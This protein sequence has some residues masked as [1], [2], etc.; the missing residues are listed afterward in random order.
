MDDL[1][2][3]KFPPD[4]ATPPSWSWMAYAGGKDNSGGIDYFNPDFDKFDWQ[5]IDSP[6]SQSDTGKGTT[7]LRTLSQEYDAN[8][9]EGKNEDHAVEIILDDNSK[10]IQYPHRCVVL[11]IQ[12]GGMLV[13]DKRHYILVI[14]ATTKPGVYERIGAGFVPGICINGQAR[15]VHIA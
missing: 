4:R 13:S 1:S 9:Y 14:E 11:G 10:V 7:L 8:A 15:Q 2:R 3:I 6:W 5:D 12:K